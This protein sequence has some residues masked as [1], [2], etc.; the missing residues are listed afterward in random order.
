MMSDLLGK[1]LVTFNVGQTVHTFSNYDDAEKYL[2]N[3]RLGGV[4]SYI[5][6][7]VKPKI[8]KVELAAEIIKF[9]D[10]KDS[11]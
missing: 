1:W 8:D 2:V 4:I 9:I 7:H 10:K 5:V 6:S 3:N 11:K